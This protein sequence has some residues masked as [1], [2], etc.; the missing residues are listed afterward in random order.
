MRRALFVLLAVVFAACQEAPPPEDAP[1]PV[2]TVADNA[3]IRTA[4]FVAVDGV[5][6]SELMA[7][8]DV[9]HHSLFRDSLDYIRPFV[10]SPDGEPVITFEGLTVA[11]HYSFADAPPADILVIPSAEGSMTTDLEDE[12]FIGWLREAVD[13]AEWVVTVCD[14][15]FPLAATGALDGRVATT[16]PSDRAALAA[17]F[18]AVD[19]RDDVRL[20]VDGKFI[21]SV[22]GGMSYEPAFY[23]VERLYGLEHARL[24][25]EGLVWPWDLDTVPHVIAGTE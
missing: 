25:A 21:T 19:V 6:N 23:L 9:F 4:A 15:A 7:P 8:Y 18:S 14:G 13:R 22:G 5:Y 17:Q 3:R 24:S 20:V 10:V 11:A 2:T 16:F 1:A 12:P